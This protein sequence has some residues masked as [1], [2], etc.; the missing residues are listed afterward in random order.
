VLDRLERT[1]I[2][3]ALALALALLVLG[4]G[5]LRLIDVFQGTLDEGVINSERLEVV[6]TEIDF[7][8]RV[9]PSEEIVVRVGNATE[10][11]QGLAGLATRRVQNQ[12]Y[13]V[14]EAV[15]IDPAFAPVD[16][17]TVYYVDAAE[18][19]H[20]VQVAQILNI[21]EAS[22]QLLVG[23]IG[24]STEGASILVVLGQSVEF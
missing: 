6:E 17:S 20:A 21:D 22:V 5:I 15:N 9:V 16:D 7:E 14:L 18:R 24:M 1:D 19:Q 4:Y 8:V 2:V 23:E 11:R 3:N 10:G 12:N 13:G